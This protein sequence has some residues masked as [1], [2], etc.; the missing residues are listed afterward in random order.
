MSFLSWLFGLGKHSRYSKHGRY[1]GHGGYSKH[2]R[3]HEYQ[4]RDSYSDVNQQYQ[5][6]MR[7]KQCNSILNKE[8]KFCSECG[9]PV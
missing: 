7:C 8:A 6:I 2:G 5:N 9:L 1:S 3:Q 4:N